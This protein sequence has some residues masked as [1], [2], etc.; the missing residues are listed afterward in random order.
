MRK[1][2]VLVAMAC[3]SMHA[4]AAEL[5][6]SSPLTIVVPYAAGGSSDALA[7]ALGRGINKTT[8]QN[9]VIENKPGGS[10]MIG[11]RALIGRPADGNTVLIAAA[12]F[13]INPYLQK[14]LP[15]DVKQDFQ[16]IT[17]LAS[18]PHVLVV[19]PAIPADDLKEYIEWAKSQN[20][21]ASFSSF[22]MGSSGHLGFELLKQQAGIEVLHVPYKGAAPAT[23]AVL[24]GEVQATLGDIGIVAP[25]IAAGKLKALAISGSERSPLLPTV[26]TFEQAGLAGYSSQTWLGLLT[27]AGVPAARVNRLSQIFTV[28]LK[29]PDVRSVLGQQ[30]M[31]VKAGTPQD[32]ALFLESEMQKYGQVIKKGNIKLE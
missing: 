10:T 3:A 2:I 21:K 30:G 22:G 23:T 1:I 4:G 18:N 16:P 24:S 15:Y 28:A 29:E 8:G 25:H 27:R 19:N 7:R 5:S 12:S 6:T 31:I 26:P 20:G 17:L 14:I 13:V 9:I 32:F 11:T